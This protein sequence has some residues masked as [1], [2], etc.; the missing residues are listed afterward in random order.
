MIPAL[1]ITTRA[2]ILVLVPLSVQL[3][4]IMLLTGVLTPMNIILA[5]EATLFGQSAALRSL[6]WDTA[7]LNTLCAGSA[8]ASRSANHLSKTEEARIKQ[9]AQEE[10][11]H[12]SSLRQQSADFVLRAPLFS[13]YLQKQDEFK[14]QSGQLLQHLQDLRI[15]A[16][17]TAEIKF[18]IPVISQ[19]AQVFLQNMVSAPSYLQNNEY[20]KAFRTSTEAIFEISKMRQELDNLYR[21]DLRNAESRWL[22]N[23]SVQTETERLKTR[24]LWTITVGLLA[25]I[26]TALGLSVWF[27]A[28]VIPRLQII[29]SNMFRFWHQEPLAG[30][31]AGRD[32]LSLIDSSFHAL[33]KTIEAA[34]KR[35]RAII[36]NTTDVICALDE[37]GKFTSVNPAAERIWGYKPEQLLRTPL[38]ALI[39][40]ASLSETQKAL[41][42]LQKSHLA[43]TFETAVIHANGTR[44]DMLWSAKWSEQDSQYYLVAHDITQRREMERLRQEFISLVSQQLKEPLLLV[45]NFLR[46]A[47]QGIHTKL[48]QRGQDQVQVSLR[49]ISRLTKLIDE[50]LDSEG[51]TSGKLNIRTASVSSR[52]LMQRS[53][54]SIAGLANKLQVDIKLKGPN[55]SLEA[56]KDRCVQVLVNL[57]GNALKF[58]PPGAGITLEC[59]MHADMIEFHVID[60]GK[61][62]PKDLCSNI[63]ERF[64][65][66]DASDASER[67]GSGLGLAICKAIVEAHGGSV[68][69]H[70]EIGKGSD[71]WF[72]I[73]VRQPENQGKEKD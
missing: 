24:E 70:S 46:E 65:Q 2:Y 57:I 1:K 58:S 62:I 15:S 22:G 63:F 36:L 14:W 56:D 66:V 34:Q 10:I 17:N 48:N 64:K 67:G 54:D 3:L 8:L 11:H 32:E 33:T 31:I 61:G 4:V 72:R 13:V 21:L 19:R 27:K 25:L 71:F 39:T 73:P 30:L 69:V 5:R 42:H 55:I 60:Q 53:L 20:E 9:T 44:K 28:S 7:V 37:T 29:M 38:E 47:D 26:S 23:P 16:A 68:G 18:W 41:R 6:I 59:R 51:L 50:L 52:E 35:E 43:T 12:S 49:S 40:D 45:H